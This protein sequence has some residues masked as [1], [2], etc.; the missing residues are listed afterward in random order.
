MVK[1]YAGMKPDAA[2]ERLAVLDVNLAAG[3]LMKIEPRKAG[4]ILNE[5]D[6]KAAALLTGI[7]AKAARKI[8]PS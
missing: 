6:S 2:A 4:V 5:M 7:M 1:I 3:I 8:D